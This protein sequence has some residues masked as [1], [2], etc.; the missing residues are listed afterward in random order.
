MNYCFWAKLLIAIPV[1]PLIA[2]MAARLFSNPVMQVVAAVVAVSAVL[3]LARK[4]DKLPMLSGMVIKR[5]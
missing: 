3:Y 1:L 5:K 4:I 2:V